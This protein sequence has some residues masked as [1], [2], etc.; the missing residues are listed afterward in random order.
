MNATSEIVY[1]DGVV[2]SGMSLWCNVDSVVRCRMKHTRDRNASS[3]AAS[4]GVLW[5]GWHSGVRENRC[6]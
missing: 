3:A 1:V 6:G 4:G 5:E 2:G